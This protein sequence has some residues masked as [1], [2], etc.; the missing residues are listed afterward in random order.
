[1]PV[2][3]FRGSPQPRVGENV[4]PAVLPLSANGVRQDAMT[5]QM[6][7]FIYCRQSDQVNFI[8]LVKNNVFYLLYL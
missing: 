1:M 8:Y 2:A 5:A 7:L 6:L 4:N 3:G